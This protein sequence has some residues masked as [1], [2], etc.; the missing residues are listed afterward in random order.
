M[1]KIIMT[2]LCMTMTAM[3]MTGCTQKDPAA[4][5]AS[6]EAAEPEEIQIDGNRLTLNYEANPT[7]GYS[8]TY[9]I[10]DES[11]IKFTDDEYVEDKA[12]PGVVGVGGREI[13]TFTSLKK[14]KAVISLTYEQN[15]DGGNK[16]ETKYVNIETD[17]NGNII[18]AT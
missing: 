6:S 7:T 10:S 2:V 9:E 8:W 1:K 3:L 4:S 16:S 18:S 15:W 12:E 5:S 13:F 11:V 17:D 14:G